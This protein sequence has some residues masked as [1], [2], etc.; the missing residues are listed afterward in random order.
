MKKLTKQQKLKKA[1]ELKGWV[2][3]YAQ[4]LAELWAELLLL[5][6]DVGQLGYRRDSDDNTYETYTLD[7][8]ETIVIK[9]RKTKTMLGQE[10]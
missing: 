7:Y 4:N 8:G 2:L 1:Q 5:H 6:G 3:H 9:K 10:K